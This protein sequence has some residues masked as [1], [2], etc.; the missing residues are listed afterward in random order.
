MWD[1]PPLSMIISCFDGDSRCSNLIR[2]TDPI[3]SISFCVMVVTF[4]VLFFIS[5]RS[6]QSAIFVHSSLSSIDLS[7][8]YFSLNESK[9]HLLLSSFFLTSSFDLPLLVRGDSLCCS[10]SIIF[11]FPTPFLS[12]GEISILERHYKFLG[13]ILFSSVSFMTS[14]FP[15]ELTFNFSLISIRV[16]ISKV[17]C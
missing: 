5:N 1:V 9:Y 12:K 11:L 14:L 10:I 7:K 16:F 15:S 6:F 13:N 17:F 2:N 8:I 4:S 3:F